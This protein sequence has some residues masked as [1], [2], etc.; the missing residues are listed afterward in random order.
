V[1]FVSRELVRLR[2]TAGAFDKAPVASE[3]FKHHRRH[4]HSPWLASRSPRRF[5]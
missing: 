3:G 1:A 5:V 2:Q 4:R